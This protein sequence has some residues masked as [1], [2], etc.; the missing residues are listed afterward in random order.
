MPRI[1]PI[2]EGEGESDAAP[3]LIGRILREYQ[4]HNVRPSSVKKAQ[5]V[6]GL[7]RVGGLERLLQ[8]A[9]NEADAS[10]ILVIRDADELCPRDVARD[11]ARRARAVNPRIPVAIVVAKCEYEAWFL[12]SLESIA[13][14]EIDGRPGI[15]ANA[16]CDEPESERSAKGWITRHM[17]GSRA[18]KET[19]DQLAMTRLIDI[20]H[21]Q[22][23]SRS[24]RRLC[25][26]V[27]ELCNAIDSGIGMVTPI[28]ADSEL[29]PRPGRD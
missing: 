10:G 13:G 28:I 29:S 6:G 19:L 7:T 22:R 5:G 20:G 23:N 2:V 9:C 21:A 18:Y 16:T 12:A 14:A 11:F 8:L 27:I 17:P 1:V 4:R 24:F 26:A 3:E 15:L 25:K